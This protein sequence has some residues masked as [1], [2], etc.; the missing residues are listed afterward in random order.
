MSAKSFT[1]QEI[2]LLR[3]NRYVSDVTDTRIMYSDEFRSHFMQEYNKGK[4]P[5]QIFRE[6]G[7]DTRM[8]G[9]KRI[10]RAAARWRKMYGEGLLE[11]TKE[12][13]DNRYHTDMYG[14]RLSEENNMLKEELA[15]MQKKLD[16]IMLWLQDDSASAVSVVR[17]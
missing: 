12:I 2:R 9:G 17:M 16:K 5:T 13:I 15:E 4:K 11:N 1:P 10:E 7:F 3:R 14:S 6:A 8:L